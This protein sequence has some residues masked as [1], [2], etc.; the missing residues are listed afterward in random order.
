MKTNTVAEQIAVSHFGRK[1]VRALARKGIR[2]VGLQHIPGPYGGDTGYCLDDNGTYRVRK[3]RDVLAAI[4]GG[5][6]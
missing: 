2:L 6:L 3:Y 5:S 1:A 4:D